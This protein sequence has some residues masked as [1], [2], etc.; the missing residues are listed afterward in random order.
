MVLA[1]QEKLKLISSSLRI[2][3]K[4]RLWNLEPCVGI[5][6]MPRIRFWGI[7]WI[8]ASSHATAQQG[9]LEI[10]RVCGIE[11]D[12]KVVKRWLSNIQEHW[13]LVIDNAD[14]P[15]IDI[16]TFFPTSNRGSIVVTTRNPD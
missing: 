12:V 3:G 9:C 15:S 10:A 13:L 5:E 4:G 8:D 6:L 16:S 7:F 1:G 14:D 2:I 11:E